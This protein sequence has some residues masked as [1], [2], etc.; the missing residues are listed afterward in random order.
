MKKFNYIFLIFILI[1]SSCSED[2]MDRINKNPNNPTNIQGQYLLTEIQTEDAFNLVG[3]DFCY[4]TSLY[5]ELTVGVH[6]QFH[7]AEI[8]TSNATSATTL[9]N[10]WNAGYSKILVCNEIIEKCS[11]GGSEDGN[12]PLL[13]MAQIL[14]AHIASIFTDA[15]GDIPYTE[16]CQPGVIYTPKLDSQESIYQDIFRLLNDGIE[17][18]N[19][20]TTFEAITNQDLFFGGDLDAWEKFAY[21]LKAR[22]TMRL[23]LK[24]PQYQEVLD[25]L[26]MSFE[27][28]EEATFDH[29]DGSNA[30]NPIYLLDDYRAS[31][32]S[33]TS[34][35]EKIEERNDP[36]FDKFFVAGGDDGLIFAPN[37]S[38]DEIQNYY[39][40]SGLLDPKAPV[41]ILSYHEILFLKA[42]ALVR[43][44]GDANIA[45]AETALKEGIKYAFMKANL[46]EAQATAYYDDIVVGKF[47]ADPLSEIMHQKYF[48]FF[49]DESF[50]MFN[51]IRRWK[52]MGDNA[53]E[54]K[55]PLFFPLRLPYGSSDVTTNANVRQ[56]YGNGDYIRTEN[57]WWAGGTR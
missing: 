12:Y 37:G 13:G 38:P 34:L 30:S 46:T 40:I 16:A 2:L 17:N 31:L 21:G 42:E 35:K 18:L 32:G 9:N 14:K 53:I 19:K 39:G 1:F 24:D 6:G 22:Y 11:E 50:E 29:F 52:A 7:S 51:D 33:S 54:L 15:F 20:A 5:V 36:R 25:L 43:L 26:A 44:G 8:R 56:A 49:Y 4:Y 23:S 41:Y 27:E 55:N 57:V 10:G 28:G 48:S 47:Q 3:G 45:L